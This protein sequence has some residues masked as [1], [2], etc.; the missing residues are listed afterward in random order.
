MSGDEIRDLPKHKKALDE[1]DAVVKLSRLAKTLAPIFPKKARD[2]IAELDPDE[3]ESTR[4]EMADLAALPDRFNRSFAERGWVMFEDMNAEVA[5]QAV[6]LA[7]G[8]KPQEGEEIL[9][10]FWTVDMI[11]VHIGRLKR[12]DAFPSRWRLAVDAEGLY[13]EGHYHACTLVVLA[14]LDGMVQETS[15]RFLRVSQNF[16]AEKTI[17]EAWDSI[18]GHSTGL[19]QLKKLLL[20]QR[21]KTNTEPVAIPYRHGIVHGM[22]VNFNLKMVAAKAGRRYS[23]LANGPTWP[24]KGN[25]R[26]QNENH[27]NQHWKRCA[28]Q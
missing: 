14:V 12:V 13:G 8:G 9:V 10:D 15:A 7:E 5:T 3:L 18:A 23:P 11:R 17:L 26:S 4:Q 21:K 25:L 2:A 27:P 24:S 28:I 22:D 1:A 20:S 19:A 6:N 16:S